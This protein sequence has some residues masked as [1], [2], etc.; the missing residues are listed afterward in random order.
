MQFKKNIPAPIV[1]IADFDLLGSRFSDAVEACVRGGVSWIC[2]RAKNSDSI[3]RVK[4][5]AEIRERCPSAFLSING[6][7]EACRRLN[8]QGLH[9]P[10]RGFDVRALRTEFPQT[11][12]GVSCHSRKELVAA[13]RS[14]AD[15]AFLS[16][17][18]APVSK[19]IQSC[20][21]LGVDG[22]TEMTGGLAMPVFA[23]AGATPEKLEELS[24]TPA[25]GI[26]V[27]GSLFNCSDVETRA[28]EYARK[29]KQLDFGHVF[30]YS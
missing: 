27:C 19:K 28:I 30:R 25:A 14:G 7:P 29:L 24:K 20:E 12:L 18:F 1:A 3:A 16:P 2:L 15:Y 4:L 26:A 21:V 9:L 11:L 23:L 22:F 17:V 5:G 10:S 13:E 8:A 6:D